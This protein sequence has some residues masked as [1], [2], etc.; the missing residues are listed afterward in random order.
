MKSL[1]NIVC[2][3]LHLQE[4]LFDEVFGRRI[5]LTLAL[6]HLEPHPRK[7]SLLLRGSLLSWISA[8]FNRY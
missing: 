5:S 2:P 3:H 4:T 6:L 7:K 1:I 8:F